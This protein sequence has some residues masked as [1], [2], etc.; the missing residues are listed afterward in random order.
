M[1]LVCFRTGP[2]A[3]AGE[4]EPTR[5]KRREETMHQN[6]RS[7]WLDARRKGIGGSDAAAAVALSPWKTRL[8]LWLEKTGQIPDGEETPEM[9]RGTLLE[10]VVKQLY[11]DATGHTIETPAQMFHNPAYPWAIANLDGIVSRE[12]LLECKTARTRQG[13][14]DPGS[15]EIPM[16]YLIQVQHY[17]AV[18]DFGVCDVAVLFGDFEFATFTVEA[19]PDFA[20]LLME[21]E[22]AFWQ[23][24]IDRVPPAPQLTEEDLRRRWPIAKHGPQ[25]AASAIALQ[26][27][28]VLGAVKARQKELEQIEGQAK[29]IIMRDM[30]EAEELVYS[31]ETIATWKS[32]KGSEKFDAKAF[33]AAHP[34][35]YQ[36]FMTQTPGS[37]RLLL[38]EK[39]KC[40]TTTSIANPIPPF[41]ANLLPAPQAEPEAAPD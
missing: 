2:G 19:D 7:Q 24:V 1:T 28:A 25:A 4:N 33:Q 12:R 3:T 11:A 9:R 32:A 38:K 13:W 20:S 36:Q 26:A 34:A 27:A 10:P 23:L 41:P 37:R 31:G 14:G 15:G 22:A 6:D 5:E 21:R 8:E 39:S 40:L 29:A 35:L 30:Q 17:L 16:A 18:A